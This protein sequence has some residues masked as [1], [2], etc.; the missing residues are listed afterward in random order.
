MGIALLELLLVLLLLLGLGLFWV[1]L[2][3]V[4]I[5]LAGVFEMLGLGLAWGWID[6][7]RMFLHFG[8]IVELLLVVLLFLLVSLFWLLLFLWL[9]YAFRQ[10]LL[11]LFSRCFADRIFAFRHR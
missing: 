7:G 8:W 1:V 6:G 11:S 4:F 5:D 3:V 2:E 9:G 10:V